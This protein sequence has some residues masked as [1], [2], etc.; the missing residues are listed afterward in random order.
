MHHQRIEAHKV[1]ASPGRVV[2]TAHPEGPGLRLAIVALTV[3]VLSWWFG[4]YGPRPEPA[5]RFYWFY[6]FSDGGAGS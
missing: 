3:L 4:D 6:W 5:V 2:I 1:E